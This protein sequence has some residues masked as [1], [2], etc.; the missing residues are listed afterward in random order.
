MTEESEVNIKI[1]STVGNQRHYRCGTSKND[2][3]KTDDKGRVKYVGESSLIQIE[4]YLRQ[5]SISIRRLKLVNK[6][7]SNA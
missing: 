2:V 1:G 5:V 4:V 6:Q 3:K 7:N